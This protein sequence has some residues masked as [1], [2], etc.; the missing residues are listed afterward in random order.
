MRA[1]ME[2]YQK[3]AAACSEYRRNAKAY[4]PVNSAQESDIRSCYNCSHFTSKEY[5]D[6]DLY[7]KIVKGMAEK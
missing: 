3:V 2:T 6:I 7:D 4:S 5:C 1:S